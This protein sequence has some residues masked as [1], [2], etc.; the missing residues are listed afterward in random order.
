MRDKLNIYK[1]DGIFLIE[2]NMQ[3]SSH[4]SFIL[5]NNE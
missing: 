1:S 5:K 3:Y 4:H 2:N